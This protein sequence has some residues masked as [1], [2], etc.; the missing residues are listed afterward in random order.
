[1]SS[2]ISTKDVADFMKAQLNIKKY[3]Y[4]EDVVY[5]IESRFGSDFV[6]IN[7][8]GNLAIERKVLNK[9]REITPNVVWERGERC[10]RLREN[11]DKPGARMQE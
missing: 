6:Y 10:W 11:Y 9:F 3:L 2:K 5:E 7:E 4:Q 8:N 1:M